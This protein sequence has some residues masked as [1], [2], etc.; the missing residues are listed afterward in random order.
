MAPAELGDGREIDRGVLA[1]SGV[2]A[3]AG[4]DTDDAILRQGLGARRISASSRV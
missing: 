3:T 1:D 4:L 2:R